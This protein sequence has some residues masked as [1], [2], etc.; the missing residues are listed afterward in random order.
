[1]LSGNP[2][3]NAQPIA[4]DA[5]ASGSQTGT[6]AAAGSTAVY[7][8]VAPDSETFVLRQDAA[9]GS[10]LDSFLTVFDATGNPIASNDDSGGT[11]NSL[12]AL[13]A[14]AGQTYYVQAAGFG[15]STGAYVL[16]IAPFVDDFGNAPATAHVITLDATGAGTQ[17]GSIEIPGNV[18]LFK[19]TAPITGPLAI[20]QFAADTSNLD[21][22]L[23]VLDSSLNTIASNDDSAG[24]LN[25]FVLINVT[26]GQTYFVAATGYHGSIG[27]Y[28]LS[29][30]PVGNDTNNTIATARLLTLDATGAALQLGT[31]YYPGDVNYFQFVS[32]ITGQLNIQQNAAAG[33]NLDSVLTVYDNNHQEIA[34]N[35]DS[36]DTPDSEVTINVTAGQTYFLQAAGYLDSTGSYVLVLNPAG[37]LPPFDDIGNTFAD[38]HTVAL[39]TSGSGQQTGTVALP[40][41]SDYFQFVAPVTGGMSLTENPA[42]GSSLDPMLTVFDSNRHSLGSSD[43]EGGIMSSLVQFNV[44]AGQSYFVEATGFDTSTG[45]YFLSFSTAAL[46]GVGV[47]KTFAAAPKLELRPNS[48]GQLGTL[49]FAGDTDLFA[50]RAPATGGLTVMESPQPGSS[51]SCFVSAFDG[52]GQPLGGNDDFQGAGISVV[53]FNVTAGQVYFIQAA[54]TGGTYGA[55]GLTFFRSGLITDD[56][57]NTFAGAQPIV[58]DATGAGS[59]AGTVNYPAIGLLPEGDSDVFQFVAPVTGRMTIHEDPTPGSPLAT[60]LLVYDGSHQLL[61]TTQ[62]FFDSEEVLSSTDVFNVVAGQTYFVRAAGFDTYAGAYVL[63]FRTQPAFPSDTDFV[64]PFASAQPVGLDALGAGTQSGTIEVSGDMDFFS[65]VATQTGLMSVRQ[66]AASGSSLDSVLRVFDANQQLLA[67][68][69]DT[70]GTPNSQV[71]FNVTAGQ[72]YYVE[73]AGF[74]PTIGGYSLIFQTAAPLPNTPDDSLVTAQPLALDT[75]GTASVAGDLTVSGDLDFYRFEASVTGWMTVHQQATAAITGLEGRLSAIDQFW[76]PISVRAAAGGAGTSTTEFYVRAGHTY[77]VEVSAADATTGPYALTLQT[78]SSFQDILGHTPA[79]ALPVVLDKNGQ[80]SQ[81]GT[82]LTPGDLDFFQFVPRVTGPIQ[83]SMTGTPGSSLSSALAVADS[84]GHRVA[85]AISSGFGVATADFTVSAGQTYYLLAL[86]AGGSTGDYVLSFAP[87]DDGFGSAFGSATPV[88]LDATGAGQIG[89]QIEGALGTDLFQFVALVTGGMTIRQQAAFG[90]TL[91]SVLTVFDS[92]QQPIGFSDQSGGSYD[93]LVQFN[94]VAGQTYYVQAAGFGQ[95][96]GAYLL[97]FSTGASFVPDA[98]TNF[99]TATPLTLDATGAGQVTGNLAVSGQTDFYQFVSPITG[100]LLIRQDA[101]PGSFLDSVLTVFDGNQQQIAFNDDSGR[102]ANSLVAVPVVAGQTYYVEAAGFTTSTG[103]YVLT[104]AAAQ[105]LTLDNQGTASQAGTITTPGQVGLYQV[106]ASTTGALTLNLAADSGSSLDGVLTVTDGTEVLGFNDDRASDTLD[107]QVTVNV[108]AGQT[109]LIEVAGYQHSTGAYR[110]TVQSAAPFTDDVGSNFATAP[111]IPVKSDL[112]TQ[113]GN[114]E[115]PGNVDLYQFTVDGTGPTLV[116]ED[117][118]AGSSL[119]PAVAVY[120]SA[121]QQVA[122]KNDTGNKRDRQVFFNA[123][124]GQTFYVQ[125]AA[126][127]GSGAYVLQITPARFEIASPV[128]NPGP[129]EKD[130][131]GKGRKEFNRLELT[132]PGGLGITPPPGSLDRDRTASTASA[133]SV[134]GQP[135]GAGNSTSNLLAA[136]SV[137][138]LSNAEESTS[139]LLASLLNVAARD[140]GITSTAGPL[141]GT[142]A[143]GQTLAL[144]DLIRPELLV[145][146]HSGTVEDR[147]LAP[148]AVE[149]MGRAL[150]QWLPSPAEVWTGSEPFWNQLQIWQSLKGGL[151]S[152]VKP[153]GVTD[154]ALID[155]EV[156]VNALAGVGRAAWGAILEGLQSQYRRSP[157]NSPPAQPGASLPLR[158]EDTSNLDLTSEALVLFLSGTLL[159]EWSER[160]GRK[161]ANSGHS[162]DKTFPSRRSGVLR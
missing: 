20:R 44:A 142:A 98:G 37:P 33:S 11:L 87:G 52:N 8:F 43:H 21:S 24:T 16:S 48:G 72:T 140:N 19:F 105:T 29:F 121:R 122:F 14:T 103:P 32:P 92:N 68:D 12:V 112:G 97:S 86:G 57:A 89:G 146:L 4:L 116:T 156:P 88:G 62:S 130:A 154:L 119:L 54:G 124:A 153:L 110:L 3:P 13:N 1:L 104:F 159:T 10:S 93:S 129:L 28:V 39:D 76:Q 132:P 138:G 133:I 143:G 15:A 27:T 111:V 101:S 31:L 107:S 95:S 17:T 102:T 30:T 150:R 161:A 151:G 2:F 139:A 152:A 83:V 106:V 123:V 5:T 117:P 64:N 60:Q 38:A 113:N 67:T 137:P 90:S 50:F 131:V 61:A 109:Y 6:I 40:G 69:D 73:A 100:G 136:P 82:I 53:R 157:P 134:G 108:V 74:G 81:P 18:D 34:F 58:L 23:I 141:T 118:A 9:P 162:S 75:S 120:N 84:T 59:Q 115:V 42:P 41:E 144:Q 56:F 46:F 63:T 145:V 49:H 158:K 80:A 148:T 55:Y 25:S 36:R 45:S 35:D 78:T 149:V 160:K 128:S 147:G 66:I 65:V 99:A 51:L 70:G 94:V 91:D 135:S 155:W 47:G 126:S 114:I 26:Q 71:V 127:V 77:Y 96:T 85:L 7:S 79:N 125:V 22:L